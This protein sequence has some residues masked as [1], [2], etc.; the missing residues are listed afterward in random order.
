M[1]SVRPFTFNPFSENTYVL[2]DETKQCVIVD[3]GCYELAEKQELAGFIEENELTPVAIY[4]THAHIDHI[5]GNNF[6]VGK[7]DIPI[8][9]SKI[10]TELLKS[11]FVYGEMWGVKVEPSPDPTYFIEEGKELNFGNTALEVFFT[12]GHSPG[13]YSFLH[14][15][16]NQLFSGDVLFNGS[17]GRTDLP[18]GNFDILEKSIL[19]KL[20]ILSDEIIVFSGHGPETTIGH[21][22]KTNPF[23][24]LISR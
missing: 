3:P 19:E 4:L 7:Y 6:I 14:R 21:E 5:L 24:S 11:A 9:M 20:Y 10:E 8:Y 17:I 12:P 22:K 1:L 16:T 13:S 2:Y 23:V 15:P 18:G